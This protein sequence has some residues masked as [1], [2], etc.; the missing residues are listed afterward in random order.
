M[1]ETWLP[2]F[3]DVYGHSTMF[4]HHDFGHDKFPFN[5]GNTIP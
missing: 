1:V 5:G 4:G 3:M 2:C